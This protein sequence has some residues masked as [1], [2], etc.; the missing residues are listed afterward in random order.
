[1]DTQIQ[2]QT[3]MK[4]FMLD[5]ENKGSQVIKTFNH[6]QFGTIRT[7]TM[8]NGQV[9]FVGKDVAEVLGYKDPS[10][11]LFDRVDVEDKTSLL[12]QQSGSN[13]KANTIFINE[14][15]L[16]AL[17]LS[18]KLPQAREFK[19]WVTAE[20]LPQ[21]RQTG[22]YIPVNENDDDKAIL[23][24]AVQILMRTVERKDA[25]L[26]HQKPMVEFANAVTSNDDSILIRDLAKLLTQNGVPIGQGRLFYW[27]RLNGYLFQRETRPIQKW[28]EKGIFDTT[29]SLVQTSGSTKQRLTTKVTGKGQQYFLE[30][31]MSG[32][33]KYRNGEF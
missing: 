23:A 29:L 16:Y 30:G 6:E 21:I 8:P 1:M 2:V 14:S 25:L 22:G 4:S 3:S 28:V 11:A 18:S 13:Y 5:N 7:M 20:V 26:E 12:I 27:L 33:F 15:G 10:R 17:I 24:R 19:H 9:G 32:R 31:F